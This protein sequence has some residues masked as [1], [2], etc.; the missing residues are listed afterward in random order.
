MCFSLISLWAAGV[1]YLEKQTLNSKPSLQ[2]ASIG[3]FVSKGLKKYVI[4][5]AILLT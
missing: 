2:S 3:L 1:D 4:Y 5:S